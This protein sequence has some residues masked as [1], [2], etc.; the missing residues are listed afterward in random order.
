MR[1]QDEI[2]K[3][4]MNLIMTAVLNQD[5]SFES[6]QSIIHMAL[7]HMYD[8]GK[9]DGAKEIRIQFLDYLKGENN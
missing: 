7:N 3:D 9:F 5:L 4:Q 1:S 2:L 6:T 8:M